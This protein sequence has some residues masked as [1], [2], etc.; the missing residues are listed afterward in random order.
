MTG[1]KHINHILAD[2][3]F[4]MTEMYSVYSYMYSQFKL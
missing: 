2:T 4:E 1:E 3:N